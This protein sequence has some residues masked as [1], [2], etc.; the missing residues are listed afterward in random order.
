MSKV[1]LGG[2]RNLSRL[3]VI[4]RARLSNLI[5]KRHA[6]LVGDANGMDAAVQRFLAEQSYRHVAVYCMDGK[7]RNNIGEW[8]LVSID[9]G[10]RSKNFNYFAMKDIAMSES[11]DYGFMLWDGKSRGTLNNIIN[12]LQ[13][14]KLSLVY[15][16]PK[17]SFF[18]VKSPIDLKHLLVQC[19]PAAKSELGK[20]LSIEHRLQ[21]Q[22]V[23]QSV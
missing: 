16:S 13:R 10:G 1:F 3:N 21:S 9:S 14:N 11:A 12:L 8:D 19:D 23:L 4:T 7:C 18:P 15:F 20:T 6:I 22:T 5:A 2:S 17:K